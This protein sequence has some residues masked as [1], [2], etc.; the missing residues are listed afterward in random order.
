MNTSIPNSDAMAGA[1]R[2]SDDY[3]RAAQPI[4]PTKTRDTQRSEQY[5]SG[6]NNVPS[7]GPVGHNRTSS[8]PLLD[9]AAEGYPVRRD[10]LKRKPV[11]A[12]PMEESPLTDQ[13]SRM[14]VVPTPGS[15][16]RDLPAASAIT[17]T[18]G[19]SRSQEASAVHDGIAKQRGPISLPENMR[20]PPNFDLS[21]SERTDVEESWQPA[22]TRQVV[23]PQRHEVLQEAISRDIH[24]HHY[25][26]HVQPIKVV[27]I[28]PAKHYSYNAKTGVKTEI[29]APEGWVMPDHMRPTQPNMAPL[30]SYSRHYMVDED[31]PNGVN[32]APPADFNANQRL[33]ANYDQVNA[34]NQLRQTDTSYAQ[35]TAHGLVDNRLVGG[36]IAAPSSVSK[37]GHSGY[38]NRSPPS[39]FPTTSSL[40]D[41][42][43]FAS[44][45]NPLKGNAPAQPTMGGDLAHQ[46][47]GIPASTALRHD[48]VVNDANNAVRHNTLNQ[49][50]TTTSTTTTTQVRRY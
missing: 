26:T 17:G 37:I 39:S 30:Q 6:Y 49:P 44:T 16:R 10:S 8:N 5:G 3:R 23:I 1:G 24:V 15:A 9:R 21:H 14:N 46:G 41:D 18:V 29:P 12:R 50:S 2:M 32:E 42:N 38:D 11:T 47:Q 22:V 4:T 7:G 31:H 40:R 25:F 28:L 27:E 33:L 20:L 13:M 36:P 45:S 43:K 19:T 34:P 48:N 35:S